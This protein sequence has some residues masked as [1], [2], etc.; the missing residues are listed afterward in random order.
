MLTHKHHHKKCPP[1]TVDSRPQLLMCVFTSWLLM[2]SL[3]DYPWSL[4]EL[5]SGAL[6]NRRS[7]IWSIIILDRHCRSHD[8]HWWTNY[9]LTLRN[10]VNMLL[11]TQW[12]PTHS[13]RLTVKAKW[14]PPIL[15]HQVTSGGYNTNQHSI[16]QSHKYWA[17]HQTFKVI[18]SLLEHL[19]DK[20]M[21]P[22]L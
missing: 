15:L 21:A 14:A 11:Q 18:L 16:E 17:I 3:Q 9:V 20:S 12:C 2:C 4:S 7:C 5:L 22:L 8:C 1:A 19:P 10:C 6:I 13:W